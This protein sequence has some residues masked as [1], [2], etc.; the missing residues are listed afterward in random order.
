MRRSLY[1]AN[2]SS[3]NLVE[4]LKICCCALQGV[5]HLNNFANQHNICNNAERAYCP[6]TIQALYPFGRNCNTHLGK[7][8]SVKDKIVNDPEHHSHI[9]VDGEEIYDRSSFHN[10]LKLLSHDELFQTEIDY[11]YLREDPEY[12]EIVKKLRKVF[13]DALFEDAKRYCIGDQPGEIPDTKGQ[14]KSEVWRAERSIRFPASMAKLFLKLPH[15]CFAQALKEHLWNLL[16]ASSSNYGIEMEEKARE[17]YIKWAQSQDESAVVQ[18]TGMWIN[19]SCPQL[20]CSP[21][22]IVT[23]KK[24]PTKLLEIKCP[25][26]MKNCNLSDL[27]NYFSDD[28][29]YED[30]YFHCL[31]RNSDGSFSLK[32]NSLFWFQIQF[33]MGILNIKESHFMV[34]SPYGFVVSSVKFDPEW[35]EPAKKRLMQLHAELLVPEYFLMRTPRFFLPLKIPLDK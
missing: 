8:C 25:E 16:P 32:E 4:T 17:D 33:S 18:E 22:G 29:E 35:W 5:R 15:T 9:N 28:N 19:P 14:R 30:P 13:L 23:S 21:D 3:S 34:W 7:S 27:E 6:G 20:S 12:L 26:H 10:E 1:M 24:F 31:Q 11:E 2:I